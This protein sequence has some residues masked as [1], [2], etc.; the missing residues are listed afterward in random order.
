MK[1]LALLVIAAGAPALG[2]TL[3][4]NGPL[5]TG[6]VTTGGIVAPA[7]TVWSELATPANTIFGYGNQGTLGNYMADDFTVTGTWKVDSICFFNYQTGSGLAS[8]ITGIHVRI[9]GAAGPGVGVPV[10]DN[11]GLVAP[12]SSVF[13]GIYRSTSAGG[14][15]RP[16]MTSD[17]AVGTILT[18]GTYW[19]DWGVAG[20]L[21]SGPWQPPVTILGVPGKPGGN[22]MQSISFGA[23]AAVTDAGVGQDMPFVIKG[24]PAPGSLALL[25]LG[26]LVAI[27]RRR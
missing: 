21:T 4:D 23:Y 3:W 9:W 8:T 14:T 20:T 22:A 10:F 7:G 24:V 2:A 12:T 5:A 6:P 11:G 13:S 26:G 18:A 17:M 19:L 15:T 1:N 16:I 25:G 27:R